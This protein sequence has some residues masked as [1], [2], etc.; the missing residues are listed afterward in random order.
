MRVRSL[1]GQL[2]SATSATCASP[3]LRAQINRAVHRVAKF[4]VERLVKLLHVHVGADGAELARRMWINRKPAL[5]FI[6]PPVRAPDLCERQEEPLFRGE[7]I[8][9]LP[10][11]GVFCKRTLERFVSDAGAAK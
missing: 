9:G 5:Q 10:L 4:D 2:R 1:K 7:S 3:D 8:D 11:R 6:L